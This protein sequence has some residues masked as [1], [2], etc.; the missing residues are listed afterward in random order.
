[1][2]QAALNFRLDGVLIKEITNCA[3]FPC[4]ICDES[5]GQRAIAVDGASVPSMHTFTSLK[6]W[7]KALTTIGRGIR[8]LLHLALD[9]PGFIAENRVRPIS[10]AWPAVDGAVPTLRAPFVTLSFTNISL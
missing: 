10:R 7:H 2:T 1:M 8:S 4:C 9:L 6:S 3:L 5:E